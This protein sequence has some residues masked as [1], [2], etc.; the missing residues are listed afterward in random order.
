MLAAPKLI[1]LCSRSKPSQRV[2]EMV[3]ADLPVGEVKQLLLRRGLAGGSAGGPL[4]LCYVVRGGAGLGSVLWVL[5]PE[6][7]GRNLNPPPD[8]SFCA[9]PTPLWDPPLCPQHLQAPSLE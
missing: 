6:F 4:V 9:S 3:E 1:Y 2:P 5:G 8:L 7:R